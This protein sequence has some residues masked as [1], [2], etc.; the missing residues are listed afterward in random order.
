MLP[1]KPPKQKLKVTIPPAYR[2]TESPETSPLE[3]PV[4]SEATASTSSDS[5]VKDSK[6]RDDD[7]GSGGTGKDGS[8]RERTEEHRTQ[9]D[10]N[11]RDSAASLAHIGLYVD[12]LDTDSLARLGFSYANS[13]DTETNRQTTEIKHWN[14]HAVSIICA[15]RL[16]PT[17]PVKFQTKHAN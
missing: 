10:G 16:Y 11:E 9:K 15:L 2:T 4:K 12:N 17:I 8:G 13:N 3:S 5:T 1:N 7:I 6:H 14:C